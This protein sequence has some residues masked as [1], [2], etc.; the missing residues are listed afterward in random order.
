MSKHVPV[1]FH[2][3][4]DNH[5]KRC[6]AV[7]RQGYGVSDCPMW[8][9]SKHLDRR[10]IAALGGGTIVKDGVKSEVSPYDP[11][12]GYYTVTGKDGKA[13]VYNPHNNELVA[14]E[15]RRRENAP[16][17]QDLKQEAK[18]IVPPREEFIDVY[19]SKWEDSTIVAAMRKFNGGR[20]GGVKLAGDKV[21]DALVSAIYDLTFHVQRQRFMTDKDMAH[22]RTAAVYHLMVKKLPL[23]DAV[24]AGFKDFAADKAAKKEFV[25][26]RLEKEVELK[27]GDT[28]VP[29]DIFKT[30]HNDHKE[31]MAKETIEK[32]LRSWSS[33]SDDF[34]LS[35]EEYDTFTRLGANETTRSLRRYHDALEAKNKTDQD[36]QYH[37]MFASLREKTQ[38]AD[39]I[40]MSEAF[41]KGSVSRIKNPKHVQAVISE[42]ME[43]GGKRSLPVRQAIFENGH[44]VRNALFV[45]LRDG[46]LDQKRIDKLSKNL[47]MDSDE[48]VRT[49]YNR[50]GKTSAAKDIAGVVKGLPATPES[51]TDKVF[52]VLKG[53]SIEGVSIVHRDHAEAIV[54]YIDE[55]GAEKFMEDKRG[56][57]ASAQF[58]DFWKTF[59]SDGF[60]VE[61]SLKHARLMA[62]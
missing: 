38:D 31:P 22:F 28:R 62:K 30:L 36:D 44:A 58:I 55:F 7:H 5:W 45:E 48:F 27:S 46:K 24:T 19:D 61:K 4:K 56:K 41:L 40:D 15:E 26:P 32:E 16:I 21:K 57:S 53:G 33:F 52:G 35:D 9:E 25:D 49:L 60:D 12:T 50:R 3:G 42:V 6:V 34:E 39:T 10:A 13:K 8:N 29:L 14:W 11:Q 23:K 37:K 43:V 51:R 47:D 18:F 59:E 20:W 2:K 54:R 1:M 17:L